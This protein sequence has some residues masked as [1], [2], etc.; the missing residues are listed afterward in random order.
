MGERMPNY[1]LGFD[2]GGTYTDAVIIDM[3][4]GSVVCSSKSL[5]TRNDLSLGIQGSIEGFDKALFEHVKMVSLSSTLATNS[6]V[7]GKGCR[8]ALIAVGRE[9]DRSIPVDEYICIKGGILRKNNVNISESINVSNV[10]CV[11]RQA[12]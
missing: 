3:E 4:N 11:C 12:K 8:V 1:G 7:E 9:F 2:T 6:I 5:T 10:S